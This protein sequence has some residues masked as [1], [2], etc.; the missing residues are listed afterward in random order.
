MKV[1][2]LDAENFSDMQANL[3]PQLEQLKIKQ[4][5]ILN[6]ELLVEEIFWRTVNLGKVAQVKVRILKNFFGKVQIQMTAEGSPYNP[7]LE[8]SD[9][10]EEDEEYYRTLIL[11]ANRQSLSWF[12]KNNL[13]VVTISVRNES[14]KALRLILGG[15]LGG[16]ICGVVMKEILSPET[17]A[18]VGKDVI[19]PATKMFLNALGL[20]IAPVIFFSVI[21]GII[22][23]GA[24]AGVG[25][26]S[27]KIIGF[28]LTTS[29]IASVIGLIIAGIFF[30]GSVPQVGVVASAQSVTSYEFSLI[31]FIVDIIPADLVNPIAER[32]M[33]QIIFIA[34]LFGAAFVAL[35][36]K[37][38][39]LQEF[40]KNCNDLF[41]KLVGMIVF[42]VPLIAFFAMMNLA[43]SM[44]VD[45]ILM[46]GRLILA[47]LIGN[48]TMFG[49]YM[50]LILFVGKIS[51][52]PFLKKIPS[53]WS[54]PFA[55][56]SSAV[57]MP[58][59][60]DF[61]AKKMG[62]EPKISAFAIPLGTTINMDGA[63]IYFPVAA[64]MFLKMYG[65]E[66]DLNALIT[67][68][69]MTLSLSIGAP[70]VPNASV[71]CIITITSMFGL[72]ADIAGI[73]F[74]ISTLCDRI[75][76]VFNVTGDVAANVVLARTKTLL[77][78][79]IY[80]GK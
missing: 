59:T 38:S 3:E 70:A 71:I 14:N 34:V 27:S 78:E 53:L 22:S 35:G 43:A 52:L 46:M 30:S 13:N 55:T 8:V 62:V 28:Y 76:T 26:I 56:S 73:L 58:F 60:L 66:V 37:I 24:S 10:D 32:N 19:A 11:K 23:M 64:I 69:A 31:N 40:V 75:I 16:L 50:L 61:C 77:D 1:F 79:K 67:I 2:H 7:L 65:V 45:T 42:F 33:L 25:R 51:P 9:W 54:V 74:C 6:A 17:I 15:M 20:V 44:D 36:N 4:K 63:C 68:F 57:T 12:H 41:M 48:L 5:D 29:L 49:V 47:Q 21:C 72:P 18:L 80:L 39:L